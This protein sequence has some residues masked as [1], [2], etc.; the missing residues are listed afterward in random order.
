[1]VRAP[2]E[3]PE[4]L[5]DSLSVRA[6]AVFVKY[7]VVETIRECPRCRGGV[8]LGIRK[9]GCGYTTLQ[10]TCEEGGWAHL[11]ECINSFGLLVNVP[12]N[13]WMPFLSFFKQLRLGHR[14]SEIA[15]ELR[16]G[17]GAISVS[18]TIPKWRRLYQAQLH[19]ACEINDV[20]MIGKEKGDVVV[21]DE[22]VV[23]VH[24]YDGF[25]AITKGISK[26]S[27]R[28]RKD[29][30]S[31][32]VVAKRILRREPGRTIWR[33]PAARKRPAGL[34]NAKKHV[35]KRPAANSSDRRSNGRWLWLGVLVGNK[36]NVYTHSNQKK[37]VTFRMMPKKDDAKSHRPR[38]LLE[39]K[40]T[41]EMRLNRNAFLVYDGWKATDSAANQLGYRHANPVKHNV[42]YRD[43]ETGFHTNDAESENNRLKE[44][45]FY[46]GI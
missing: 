17:Y 25:S 45:V 13:S 34:K 44:T 30:R 41:L 5:S 15:K 26:G 8:R 14:L 33:K 21:V 18:Q 35:L 42:T 32:P 40:D 36:K 24:K 37:Q 6:C 27:P 4:H 38:G 28:I 39:M 43:A 22:T 11:G 20:L 1:V 23:G 9:L 2:I 16:A 19:K 31:K 3:F 46:L 7:G 12:I 10:W 29:T